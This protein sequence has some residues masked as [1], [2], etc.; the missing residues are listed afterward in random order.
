MARRGRPTSPRTT[1]LGRY[2]EGLRLHRGWELSDL[3]REAKIPYKTLSRLEVGQHSLRD[4]GI[5]LRVASAFDIHPDQLLR[6]AALTVPLRPFVATPPP[7]AAQLDLF[8]HSATA[9]E[10]G[11]LEDYLEFLRYQAAFRRL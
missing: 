7:P 2:I 9:D 6:R 11:L 3:A 1:A 10:T 5:L 4:Q 8:P